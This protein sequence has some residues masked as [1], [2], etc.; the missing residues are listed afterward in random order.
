[1]AIHFPQTTQFFLKSW[2]FLILKFEQKLLISSFLGRN[3]WSSCTVLKLSIVPSC[4]LVNSWLLRQETFIRRDSWLILA[5]LRRACKLTV[6]RRHQI[7]RETTLHLNPY[8]KVA[9]QTNVLLSRLGAEADVMFKDSQMN[10]PQIGSKTPI[11]CV[12]E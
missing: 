5:V 3:Y 11:Y 1:M 12:K 2:R 7:S 4:V 10:D 9:W 8:T 6:I